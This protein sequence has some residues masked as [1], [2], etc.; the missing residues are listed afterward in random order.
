M[1]FR[2]RRTE[3]MARVFFPEEFDASFYISTYDDL[4][5][6]GLKEA[7]EHYFRHGMFEGRKPNSIADRKAF[8]GLIP[9][10]ASVLEIGPFFSPMLRGENV[11]YFDVLSQADLLAR[12]HSIGHPDADPPH[13]D[14]ISP[15]GDL[16]VVNEQFDYIVSSY[17]LEHQPDLVKH[18]R[19]VTAA[20]KP[21]GCYLALA[22][23]KRYCHDHFMR[24]STIGDVLDAH[25][26]G[27]K[28][29]PLRSV[30]EHYA[31]SAHNDQVRHWN[32][33]HGPQFEDLDARIKISIVAF[34]KANGGYVD[35]HAW[36]FTPTSTIQI[37]DTLRRMQYIELEA[38][39]CYDTRKYQNDFWLV[40]QKPI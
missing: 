34:E 4:R 3:R 21:G 16:T 36:Y 32:G 35:V 8:V 6:M 25:H 17:C 1:Q 37:L 40:L 39:R 23:D 26:S 38:L 28:T 12:A 18:L 5:H 27:R 31:L 24:E 19:D 20:L 7:R 11:K 22:P 10:T 29:H 9:K 2:V 30:I 33:D 14:F 13:I 15:T